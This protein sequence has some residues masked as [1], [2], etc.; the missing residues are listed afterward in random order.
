M[1]EF[2]QFGIILALLHQICFIRSSRKL[3]EHFNAGLPTALYIVYFIISFSYSFGL[4]ALFNAF[5]FFSIFLISKEKN[6][7]NRTFILNNNSLL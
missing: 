4:T 6:D 7:E 1:K 3:N 5:F 2:A